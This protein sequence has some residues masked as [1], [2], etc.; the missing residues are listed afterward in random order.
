MYHF[1][2][3][4]H[5]QF[6]YQ[7][8]LQSVVRAETR[9]PLRLRM[10]ASS[11]STARRPVAMLERVWDVDIDLFRNVRGALS[12]IYG[13]YPWGSY[14][15]GG[16]NAKIRPQNRYAGRTRTLPRA[17]QPHQASNFRSKSLWAGGA[18]VPI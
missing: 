15:I 11:Q 7:V 5:H 4:I 14:I 13:Y 3:C 10:A 6:D 17:G 12:P 1:Y 8:Q 2:I 16:F 9:V 18:C